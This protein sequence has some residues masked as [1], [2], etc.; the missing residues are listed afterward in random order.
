[1]RNDVNLAYYDD[2]V[3]LTDSYKYMSSKTLETNELLND[4]LDEYFHAIKKKYQGVS[5]VNVDD[6]EL[7]YLIN[8]LENEDSMMVKFNVKTAVENYYFGRIRFEGVN[9]KL[10]LKNVYLESSVTLG[11]I[12]VIPLDLT[13]M[14]DKKEFSL[15][16]GQI[17]V[18]KA[19]NLTGNYLHVTAILY[20]NQLLP[21]VFPKNVPAICKENEPTNIACVCGPL[22][23]VDST[24]Q[25]D[26]TD[27]SC[28]N[29]ISAYLK[30]YNPDFLFIVGPL[31]DESQLD[32]IAKWSMSESLA[33][34]SLYPYQMTIEKLIAHQIRALCK[35]LENSSVL[36]QI[37]FVPSASELTGENVFP[38]FGSDLR[39]LSYRN[40][41]F[42]SNPSLLSLDGL[43]VG[44]T[45][46]DI[47]L[48]LSRREFHK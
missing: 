2:S 45:S 44:V 10:S 14:L 47:L 19:K 38:T 15:F 20:L 36:T 28:I 29:S 24:K 7:A 32:A 23:S 48:H 30:K 21:S 25:V 13:N 31:F 39:K 35:D 11:Q 34:N 43:A 33:S 42:V 46:A 18:V 5:A 1:M 40:I 26:F 6:E 22:F 3:A 8:D 16:P 41:K 12:I 27:L 37:V 17:V 4:H 9:K